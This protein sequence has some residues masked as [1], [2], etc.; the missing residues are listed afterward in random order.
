MPQTVEQVLKD[1]NFTSDAETY[2]LVKMPANRAILAAGIVA[3][4]NTPFTA[5]ILDRDEI[6]LLLLKDATHD[7]AKRLQD[8]IVYADDYRLITLDMVLEPTLVGLMARVSSALADAGVS[9]LTYAA[10]SR[11]HF[12]VPAAQFDDAIDALKR[13]QAN[14]K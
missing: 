6:T 11:D 13:L 12:L 2:T 14:V 10:F 5:F 4:M 1:A 9:I 3:E 8:S 7:F